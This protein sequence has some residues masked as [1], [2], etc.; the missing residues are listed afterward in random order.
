MQD[1]PPL[2]RA[3][4]TTLSTLPSALQLPVVLPF[5]RAFWLTMAREWINIESLRL[6]KYLFLIRKYVNASFQYL[7]QDDWADRKAIEVYVGIVEETC[8]NPTDMKI[9]NGLRYHV[10]DVWVDELEEV[11][12]GWEERRDVLE[13]LIKPVERLQREGKLK[14]LRKSAGEC[15]EDER[16]LA[17]MGKEKKDEGMEQD[18][19]EEWGGFD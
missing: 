16:L 14:V 5:L 1:K 12:E 18:E 4:S 3:L 8:L 11:E 9:P 17:W 7:S 15:L 6:D 19:E 2:Q 10:L 13:T